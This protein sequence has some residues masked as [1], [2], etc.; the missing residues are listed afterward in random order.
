[1]VYLVPRIGRG[2]LFAE[3]VPLLFAAPVLILAA[4]CFLLW[5][6]KANGLYPLAALIV[7]VFASSG[8]QSTQGPPVRVT[9]RGVV[10]ASKENYYDLRIGPLKRVRVFSEAHPAMGTRVAVR[11]LP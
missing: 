8:L 9:V 2:L 7:F 1:M 3:R 10:M 11:G 4:F 6:K 5:G